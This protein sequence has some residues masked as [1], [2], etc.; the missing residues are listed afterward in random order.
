M[1]GSRVWLGGWVVKAARPVG[2]ERVMGGGVE[3]RLWIGAGA[4]EWREHVLLI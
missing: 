1:G 3:Q 4:R 2:V